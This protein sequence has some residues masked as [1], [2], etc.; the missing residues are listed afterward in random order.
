MTLF[1]A[2]AFVLLSLFVIFPVASQNAKTGNETEQDG[3]PDFFLVSIIEA[4]FSGTVRWHPDWPDDIPPDGFLLSEGNR[5]PQVI[6]LSG[7]KETFVVRRDSEGR[8]VEFPFFSLNGYAKVTAAYSPQGALMRMLIKNYTLQD[9]SDQAEEKEWNVIFPAGFLPYSEMSPGGSFPPVRVS[10]SDADFFV[11]FFES[12]V[13]FTE[14]LYDSGG[15]MLSFRKAV[16]NI[17]NSAWRITSIQIHDSSGTSFIDYFFDSFGNI[18]ETRFSDEALT[19]IY[20]NRLPVFWRS[21]NLQYGLQWDNRERLTV[22]RAVDE[23]GDLYVEYRYEYE[24]DSFGNWIKRQEAAYRMQFDLLTPQPLYSRGVW[25][26]RIV[27][28]GRNGD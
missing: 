18:T 13:F 4:A 11:F 26:R 14:T 27:F 28:S 9:G 15:N 19:A 6:E 25:N 8:L 1:R 5:T 23:A 20:R 21:R 10:S 3:S 22:A 12:P 2:A 16:V 7:E 24:F 17:E